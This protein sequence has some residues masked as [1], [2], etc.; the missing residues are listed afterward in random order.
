MNYGAGWIILEESYREGT[1]KLLS[2]LSPRRTA[3][4]VSAFIEQLHIDRYCS[5]RERLEY[6]KTRKAAPTPRCKTDSVA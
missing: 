3:K 2:I 1:T 6:K 4:N 5:I